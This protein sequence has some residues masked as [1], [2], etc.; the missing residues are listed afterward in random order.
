MDFLNFIKW[1]IL[2]HFSVY[3]KFFEIPS[4]STRFWSIVLISYSFWIQMIYVSI[5]FLILILYGD[6]AS[7][8]N[9]GKFFFFFKRRNPQVRVFGSQRTSLVWDILVGAW[10]QICVDLATAQS[11]QY[12]T[13]AELTG[14]ARHNQWYQ[15]RW[16]RSWSRDCGL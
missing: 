15:C 8:S 13:N 14:V 1:W 6:L 5:S 16:L 10:K 3:F 4:K 9:I 7:I 11:G 2:W 12:N